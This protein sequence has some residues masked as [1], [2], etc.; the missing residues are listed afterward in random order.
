MSGNSL[1]TQTLEEWRDLANILTKEQA[2]PT[3]H[4]FNIF[5]ILLSETDE[6]R[7]HTRFL[8]CLLDPVGPHDCGLR[9]LDLFLATL[10]E[11][12][13]QD[14]RGNL[15][16]LKLPPNALQWRVSK[17]AFSGKYGQIDILL[18]AGDF[19]LAIENKIL[20]AE[21]NQ[22]LKGYADFL[23]HSYPDSAPVLYL[24][25]EGR[26]SATHGGLPYLRISYAE[27]M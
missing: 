24:T 9:F 23:S 25:L 4:R 1:S 19:G 13:G 6:V 12:P 18:E 16:K 5:R 3:S 14:D 21:Q 20:A 2:H 26:R 8:H 10:D 27:H 7:L 11:H 15:V 22:Q 17:E